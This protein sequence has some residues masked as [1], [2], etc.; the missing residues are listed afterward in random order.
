MKLTAEKVNEIFMD[1]L[2]KDGED[3]SGHIAAEGVVTKVGFH[4]M[5]LEA[6][7]EDIRQLLQ[8]LPVNFRSDQ[9]GSPRS[10]SVPA[11]GRIRIAQPLKKRHQSP[12]SSWRESRRIPPL[13]YLGSVAI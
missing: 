2:F 5:R 7:K 13:Q 3:T 6:H 12:A 11:L 1:C 8:D 10:R 4:P 9:G